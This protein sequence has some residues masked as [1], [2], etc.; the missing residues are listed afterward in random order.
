MY[1]LVI[2]VK[3]AIKDLNFKIENKITALVKSGSGKSTIVDLLLGLQKPSKGEIF[4]K[5]QFK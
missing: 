3:D 4:R 2:Q 5:I 1:I